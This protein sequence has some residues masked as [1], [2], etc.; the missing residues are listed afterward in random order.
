MDTK[1]KLLLVGSF[2]KSPSSIGLTFNTA[3]MHQVTKSVSRNGERED[4]V[5]R[6]REG[7]IGGVASLSLNEARF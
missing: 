6:Q 1:F 4:E 5:C 7:K 3:L 2:L